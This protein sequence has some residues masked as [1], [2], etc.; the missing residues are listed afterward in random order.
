MTVNK[1]DCQLFMKR[2][3]KRNSRKI[4]YFIA[5]E[6]GGKTHRPHY[7]MIVFNCDIAT[8]SPAWELGEVHFGTLTPASTGYTLKY[9]SKGKWTPMHKNDDRLP[10]FR[11]MSKGLGKN[12]L[13]NAMIQWHHAD[14]NNR[15]YCV[16]E[17]GKK[18]AM[19]R[20]YKQKIYTDI[21][22]QAIGL[23]ALEK[24]MQK[25]YKAW[26]RDP[27]HYRNKLERQRAEAQRYK[28]KAFSNDKL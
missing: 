6:Y 23:V 5:A 26:S 14:K 18:I 19:P 11:L 13:T 22:R 15:L 12:Y 25:Q 3:R 17:D 10:E 4:K 7:H 24:M 20:Y 27:D 9:I 8:I 21:E 2:L 28:S 16:L 1:R